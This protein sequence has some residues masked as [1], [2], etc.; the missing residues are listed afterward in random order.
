MKKR[1]LLSLIFLL[2][3]LVAVFADT[4]VKVTVEVTKSGNSYTATVTGIDKPNVVVWYSNSKYTGYTV[5]SVGTVIASNVASGTVLYFKAADDSYTTEDGTYSLKLDSSG[6]KNISMTTNSKWG[7][8]EEARFY[9]FPRNVVDNRNVMINLTNASH[10]NATDFNE[11][12]VNYTESNLA[13]FRIRENLRTDTAGTGATIGLTDSLTIRIE[14]LDDWTF[15][16][17]YNSTRTTTFTLD[18]FCLEQDFHYT[19]N[20]KKSWYTTF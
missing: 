2:I 11:V 7:I 17:E 19:T 6:T 18:A 20:P 9:Y 4:T 14:S 5:A 10:M 12:F 13:L 15:V 3:T 16:S 1:I 8:A